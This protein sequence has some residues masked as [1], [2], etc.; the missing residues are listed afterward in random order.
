VLF[1]T[2]VHSDTSNRPRMFCRVFGLLLL[3]TLPIAIGLAAVAHTLVALLLTAEWQPVA[4]F[5]VVLAAAG[6]FRPINSIAASLLMASERNTL[7]L[8]A[9]LCKV[10]ALLVGMWALSPF[11]Q[12]ASAASVAL[13]I[14][15]QAVLLV[16]VLGRSGFPIRDL[17]LHARGPAAA[18]IALIAAVVAMRFTLGRVTATPAAAQLAAEILAGAGAYC[19]GA[20]IFARQAVK[21]LIVT[22]TTQISRPRPAVR[23]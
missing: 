20:W 9:E 22:I 7:L 18:A 4:G 3:I 10:T 8:A 12:V 14:G 11:G 1:P 21:E 2:L 15:L 5:L 6:V 17:L 13:A 19:L 23:T 16:C